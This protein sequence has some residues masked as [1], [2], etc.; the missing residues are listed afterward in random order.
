MKK[1]VDEH[2]TR[3]WGVIGEH[4][5]GRSGK[6]CRERWH[7]QLDPHIIKSPWTDDEEQAL[8]KAHNDL[9]NRWAE[10]AKR[11]PGRTDNAIKNHWNSAK[12][13]LLRLG[14]GNEITDED[15]TKLI[16]ETDSVKRSHQKPNTGGKARRNLPS[17]TSINAIN[18]LSP[19]NSYSN[20]FSFSDD[21]TKCNGKLK[22]DIENAPAEDKE[23]ANCLMSLFDPVC[24]GT[25][26]QLRIDTSEDNSAVIYPTPKRQRTLSGLAEAVDTFLLGL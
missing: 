23:A 17:P 14:G 3:K 24:L 4:L 20:P 21:H 1:L 12:R 15:I 7:N 9:G 26:K 22:I 11:L 2:G 13:R 5:N 8:I 25:R 16:S 18:D 6:Q 19:M 10:I